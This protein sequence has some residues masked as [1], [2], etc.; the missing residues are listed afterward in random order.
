MFKIGILVCGHVREEITGK[1][2]EYSDFFK[3]LLADDSFNFVDYFVVDGFFPSRTDE[4]DAYIL[5]GSAHGAYEDHAYIPPL[6]NLIRDAYEKG[7]VQV[8]ICFGHQILAQA[9]GGRVEKYDGGWGLGVHDYSMTLNGKQT[10]IKLNAVHQ[11][12]VVKKPQEAEVIASSAFC[13]NAGLAYGEKAISFQPHPE[14][15]ADFM[16]DLIEL[17]SGKSFSEEIA[18]E[19]IRSLAQPV[20]NEKIAVFIK[21]FIKQIPR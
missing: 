8:G 17:R 5:T 3:R 1:H 12:Q 14:F 2:G 4:C 11:D 10:L 18:N 16:T 15:A 21:D 19:A 7:I 6:E 20:E 9:L 13:Q